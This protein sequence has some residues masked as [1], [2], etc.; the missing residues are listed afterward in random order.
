MF[1]SIKSKLIVSVFIMAALLGALI[2][3]SSASLSEL[4]TTLNDL[5]NQQEFKSHVL[6]PQKDMNQ[7]LAGIDETVL[8]LELGESERAQE[9]YDG[10]VDAEQDISVEFATLEESGTGDLLAASESAHRDWE[11]A[12]EYLKIYA[13]QVAEEGGV[14]L[15]RPST[16]PTKTVDVHTDEGIQAAQ[17]EYGALSVPE[18][19]AIADDDEA[20]PVEAADNGIDGLE[21]MADELLASEQA[22]GEEAL[23]QTSQTVLYGAIIVL[24]AIIVIGLIV[25]RSVTRPLDMLKKGAERIANG[26]L[27][28]TFTDVPDDEIGAVIHSVEKMSASMKT[29][30]MNL[31]EVA[32]VVV[33]TGDEINSA[34]ESIEPKTPAVNT[35]LEKSQALKDLVGQVLNGGV[36]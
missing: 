19:E 7:F 33:V 6:I 30:I 10:T 17:A 31:E 5:Q 26:D 15:V 21:D 32:G 9:A 27:D 8:L 29:R 3:L 14:A 24:V 20:S 13:E 16:D 36:R 22:A 1:H 34:A 11:I 35:I 18:L 2:Y 23:K 28:Y 12:T 4:E 25:T